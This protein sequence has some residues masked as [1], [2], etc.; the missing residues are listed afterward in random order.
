MFSFELWQILIRNRPINADASQSTISSLVLLIK[1]EGQSE[2]SNDQGPM[3]P[4]LCLPILICHL[5][6][7]TESSLRDSAANTVRI[8]IVTPHVIFSVRTCKRNFTQVS[9]VGTTRRICVTIVFLSYKH[10]R[11]LLF[12]CPL[13]GCRKTGVSENSL[14]LALTYLWYSKP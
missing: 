8:C 1:T 13:A 11:V 5:I 12:M 10:R 4:F 3:Y 2:L 7:P 14:F 6:L 9:V